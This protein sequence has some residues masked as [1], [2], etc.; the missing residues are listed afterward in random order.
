MTTSR[1][2][3]RRRRRAAGAR[4]AC[5][6][7][8]GRRSCRR[9]PAGRGRRQLAALLGPLDDRQDRLLA[10][11][12]DAV[13]E[14]LDLRVTRRG[15]DQAGHQLAD[16]AAEVGAHH[17]AEERLEVAAQRAGVGRADVLERRPHGV[18]DQ[19][20]P[21]RPVAVDRRLGDAGAGRD[22]LDRQVAD[23]RARRSGRSPRRAPCASPLHSS[24]VPCGHPRHLA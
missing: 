1:Q 9:R 22:L 3:R 2:P 24:A 17:P 14:H 11:D 8:S 10:L 19:R 7:R 4:P 12:A 23:A 6:T 13:E 18:D 21:L 20:R 5:G 16:L 15:V